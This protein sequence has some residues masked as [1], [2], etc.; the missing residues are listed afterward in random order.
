MEPQGGSD[1]R[2]FIGR[3]GRRR[4]V[5]SKS[6]WEGIVNLAWTGDGFAVAVSVCCACVTSCQTRKER[7]LKNRW[8]TLQNSPGPK[9]ATVV[10]VGESGLPVGGVVQ[11]IDWLVGRFV[12][13]GD[14]AYSRG[15]SLDSHL[16]GR[17]EIIVP[18]PSRS[19]KYTLSFPSP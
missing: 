4:Q 17:P 2:R 15:F 12:T 13:N 19:L 8:L 10:L 9:S 3:S 7:I 5:R 18:R 11:Q 1:L 6:A 16:Y 14:A